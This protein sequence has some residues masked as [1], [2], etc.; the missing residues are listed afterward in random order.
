VGALIR[1]YG[2]LGTPVALT[3]LAFVV[4]LLLLPFGAET[5][6]KTLPA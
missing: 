2:T 1:H 6:G 3:S 5:R 4:G